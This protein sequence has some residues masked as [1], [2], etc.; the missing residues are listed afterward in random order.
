MSFI[1]QLGLWNWFILAG[2]LMIGELTAPGTYLLWLGFA[3]AATGLFALALDTGWQVQIVV[4][5][6][7]ALVAVL[8][9]YRIRPKADKASDRPFL[10]RRAEALVG[11]AFTLDEPISG[12]VGRVRVD[13]TVWRIEG[14]DA[15]TGSRVVVERVEGATLHVRAA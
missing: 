13:D 12:G 14:T 15:P 11:R 4:F 6:A 2:L 9:G 5:A 3:A 1:E 7:F 8:I 10:N